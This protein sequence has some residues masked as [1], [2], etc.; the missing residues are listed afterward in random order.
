VSLN[1]DPAAP[2]MPS[3]PV[4]LAYGAVQAAQQVETNL[5]AAAATA[6]ALGR[7]DA[8]SLQ[9]Q[10]AEAQRGLAAAV[11]S[12]AALAPD[13]A[14]QFSN[15]GIPNTQAPISMER[16]Y[17]EETISEAMR[18]AARARGV[19]S[20][21]EEERRSLTT[22]PLSNV[23]E[24]AEDAE[25]FS[26]EEYAL[27]VEMMDE[28]PEDARTF[29]P[30]TTTLSNAVAAMQGRGFGQAGYADLG[31]LA[32]L[33]S[34]IP[35]LTTLG[36]VL[37]VR[38]L[39]QDLASMG[40]PADVNFLSS[41]ISNLSM[42]VFG[43]P[44]ATQFGNI[45]G[46]DIAA[47]APL[48]AL[49]SQTLAGLISDA[50]AATFAGTG[51]SQGGLADFTPAEITAMEQG[52][53]TTQPGQTG[54][55]GFGTSPTAG[56]SGNFGAASAFGRGE[57]VGPAGEYN[58][59][60]PSAGVA[61]AAEAAQAEANAAA[62]NADADSQP[63]GVND[64]GASSGGPSDGAP[65][66]EASTSGGDMGGGPSGDSG[67]GYKEGGLVKFAEGGLVP[68]AGGGKIAIGPGGG[69][70]DLIPTSINGRRAAALSDG[71]FV[72]PADVVSMM[73]DGS[74]NAGARRLYDMMR[75]IRD[76][77]TGTTRQAGPLPV[78]QILKRSLGR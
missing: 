37:D 73:G 61:A 74:S 35:G 62:A 54:S 33:L 32:G 31:T 55:Y 64:G 67:D 71:E 70:D 13:L 53:A 60:S 27:D 15:L 14:A 17:T 3:D 4:G 47:E 9:A 69:L 65:S 18:D 39:N 11:E 7:P 57:T 30:L 63:G 75:Q 12:L 28:I 50:L 46:F 41:F 78:G 1:P 8:A 76:A 36:T 5:A 16:A 23:T 77:K 38:G 59:P 34:G 48:S 44:A 40:L 58:D 42:G 6:A 24:V 10:H 19:L 2:E 49:S 43:T 72:I 56:G 22:T 68:L 29:A 66:G 20:A 45:A 51:G 52:L 21:I 26:D 25:P